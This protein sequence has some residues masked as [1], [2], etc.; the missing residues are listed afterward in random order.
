M[1]TE[2][3]DL[4]RHTIA[5][6]DAEIAALKGRII[7]LENELLNSQD[8]DL[9]KRDKAIAGFPVVTITV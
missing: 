2:L 5:Q 9:P 4:Y 7:E 3:Q 8:P 1:N 6:K